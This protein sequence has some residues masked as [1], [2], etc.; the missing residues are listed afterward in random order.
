MSE[1]LLLLRD[2]L[3]TDDNEVPSACDDGFGAKILG[4]EFDAA[5]KVDSAARDEAFRR[6]HSVNLVKNARL[7]WTWNESLTRA[8]PL[9]K[10]T[11]TFTQN[12]AARLEA[13]SAQLEKLFSRDSEEFV[14]GLSLA[15]RTLGGEAAEVL[16]Q[17]LLEEEA[18]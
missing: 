2:A 6:A 1:M 8:K 4:T 12:H 7:P 18:E 9:E 14:E 15:K 16:A 11:G 5:L 17:N 3:R 13:V 10:R